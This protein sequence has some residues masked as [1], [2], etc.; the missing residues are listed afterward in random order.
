MS[1]NKKVTKGREERRQLITVLS[2][3]VDVL[4]LNSNHNPPTV[5][6]TWSKPIYKHKTIVHKN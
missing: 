5:K 6:G 2:H 1:N 4:I 3:H